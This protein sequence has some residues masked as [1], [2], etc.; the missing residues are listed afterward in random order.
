MEFK[1][2]WNEIEIELKFCSTS[3]LVYV[4][5]RYQQKF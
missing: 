5:M 2:N 3:F 1:M 4:E